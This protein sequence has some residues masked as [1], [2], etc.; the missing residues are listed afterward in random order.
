MATFQNNPF[1]TC[2]HYRWGLHIHSSN[3]GSAVHTIFDSYTLLVGASGGVYAL[4]G[5][6]LAIVIMVSISKPSAY[7]SLKMDVD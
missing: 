6:H 1:Y 2:L 7:N 4:V 5:A 3:A